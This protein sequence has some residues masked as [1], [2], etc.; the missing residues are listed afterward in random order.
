[1]RLRNKIKT[2]RD[3]G[4]TSSLPKSTVQNMK[5]NEGSGQLS[6]LKGPD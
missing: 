4:Q 5:K 6:N 3:I 2:A 1:M